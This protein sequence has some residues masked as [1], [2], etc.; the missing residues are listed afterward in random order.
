MSVWAVTSFLVAEDKMMKQTKKIAFSGIII[1]IAFIFLYVS[2]IVPSAKLACLAVSTACICIIIIE[3]GKIMGLISGVVLSFLSLFLVP[4]K[5]VS[6]LFIMFFSYYPLIKLFSEQKTRLKEW[7]IK[8]IYFVVITVISFIIL[9]VTGLI[10]DTVLSLLDGAMIGTV[11]VLVVVLAEC[12]FDYALS[13]I[14]GFYIRRIK[15]RI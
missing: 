7:I 10:P 1:A 4:D 5:M 6:V 11:F 13:M 9:K 3:A 8:I 12:I 14:I 2:A 15:E